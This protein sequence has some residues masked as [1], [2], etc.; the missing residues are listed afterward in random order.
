MQVSDLKEKIETMGITNDNSTIIS[1]DAQNFYPSVKFKLVK[2]A[3]KYFAKNLSTEDQN[4]IETCLEM[5][6]F[7]MSSTMLSLETHTM[8]VMETK[9]QMTKA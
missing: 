2:K 7:G 4:K 8:S 1:I 5:I 9:T 6:K 3:V